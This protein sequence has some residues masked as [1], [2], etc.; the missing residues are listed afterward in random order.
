MYESRGSRKVKFNQVY[1]RYLHVLKFIYLV[2]QSGH[3]TCRHDDIYTTTVL[4]NVLYLLHC[5][6]F[7][8]TTLSTLTAGVVKLTFIHYH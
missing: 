5:F 1:L 7:D 3:G 8:W 2:Y 6:S 4:R